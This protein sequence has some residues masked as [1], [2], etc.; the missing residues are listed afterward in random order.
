MPNARS[1]TPLSTDCYMRARH[2]VYSFTRG[3]L[4]RARKLADDSLVLMGE[5]PLLLVTRGMVSWYRLNFS[6]DPD[7]GYLDEAAAYATRALDQD[8]QN[9][10]G[11][12]LRGVVAAKRGELKLALRDLR[13]AHELKPGDSMILGELNRFMLS[14][15]LEQQDVAWALCEE[16]Q[17]IDPLAHRTSTSACKPS[18]SRLEARVHRPPNGYQEARLRWP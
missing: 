16:H 5:N 14:A 9:F 3:G 15:G 17:R 12:F 10:F 18:R 6:V 7:E 13:K 1:I 2:E 11:I 4:D 8:P